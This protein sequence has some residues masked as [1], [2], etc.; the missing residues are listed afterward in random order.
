M[1][2]AIVQGLRRCGL[3]EIG[4][5][6]ASKNATLFLGMACDGPWALEVPAGRH[7]LRA[8]TTAG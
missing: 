8:K 2:S 7:S 6:L 4:G 3:Y 5:K 1:K